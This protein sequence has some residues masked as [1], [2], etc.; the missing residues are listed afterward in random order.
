MKKIA[1][2]VR[3][4]PYFPDVYGRNK[5]IIVEVIRAIRREAVERCAAAYRKSREEDWL[6]DYTVDA[7]L[8]VAEED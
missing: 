8:K 6:P 4:V 1:E 3:E 2:W 7:I 5:G